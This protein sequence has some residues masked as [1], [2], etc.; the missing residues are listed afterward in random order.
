MAWMVGDQVTRWI[1]VVMR[2]RVQWLVSKPCARAPWRSAPVDSGK[3]GTRH[4]R[5][6]A[7]GAGAAQRLQAAHLPA[8]VPAADVLP[9]HAQLAGDLGLGAAGGKLRP[10]L[11]ADAFERLAVAHTTG[12]ATGRLAAAEDAFS[13]TWVRPPLGSTAKTSVPS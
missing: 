1:T 3:L 11:H 5:V 4:A 9:G 10:G 12:V 2:S 6:R 7:G 8:G 13:W